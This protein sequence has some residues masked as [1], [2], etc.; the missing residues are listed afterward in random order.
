MVTA[1]CM[2]HS[3]DFARELLTAAGVGMVTASCM[4]HSEDF[5]RE[6]LTAA[7]ETCLLW[8]FADTFSCRSFVATP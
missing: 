4:L 8:V 2:L 7:G 6:L 1:S 3:E 5:A